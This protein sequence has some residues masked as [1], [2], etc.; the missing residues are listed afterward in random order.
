MLY[1]VDRAPS[2]HR[3]YSDPDVSWV[4]F[5]SKLRS[6]GMPISAVRVLAQLQ[7]ITRSLSA[8]DTKISICKEKVIS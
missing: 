1:P 6:T 5:L 3:R 4:G 8:I 7:E 2:T